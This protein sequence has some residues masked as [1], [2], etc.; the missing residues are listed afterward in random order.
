MITTEKSTTLEQYFLKFRENIV[1]INQEFDSPFGIKKIIYTDWTASGRLY[2]PIEEKILNDFG[3]FVA[4][5]HT[6]TTVSGT[7]M[8]MAYHQA[9]KIIKKH[10]NADEN[11]VLITDG[12][13]MTGVVNKFQRILGLRI[14]ENLKI[15]TSIPKEIKPIVFVSHMEHHSNQTSWLETIADVVIIPANEEGLFCLENFKKIIQQY[16][17]RSFKIA[18]ITSCSNVTGIK[19]PYHEV[20]KIMHQ[21]GGVC[22]VDFACSGPYVT[23]NMHP[24]DPEAYLDAVFFSP[25]KFLGG[26]GTSGILVFN[27]NLYKNNVPDCPGGGTVSWTNPW[28]EHKYIDN[29]EDREDGGTPGFL[30]VIKTALAIQL[31]EKMGVANIL[32]REKEIVK[33]IF[34]ELRK[35]TNLVILAGQHQDRLGVISFYIDNLHYNLGVKI[36]NDRFGIQT[37]GGCSCAGTYGHYL[38]HVDQDRSNAITCNIN[39]GNLTVKPGWIRMSIHPT[40]TN[41]EIQYVC[42]AISSLARNHQEWSND[43][44][45]NSK[46][47][48]YTH[49]NAQPIDTLIQ[50]WF[51]I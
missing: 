42:D 13:G 15:Y 12:T 3:P 34:K 7:A 47:N 2:K 21:N 44:E 38:L 39:S 29:I 10:V 5:T 41:D 50:N 22:F 9:R 4:N 33:Y 8:T 40:T 26:P 23:I 20:A 31:K 45:Y 43:Y 30:Q 27:K 25:H 11:D 37:R 14:C 49:T 17:D 16:K 28:G 51:E 24:E 18:S 48:E 35:E 46:T 32:E 36:L 6:E 19:T 1:G